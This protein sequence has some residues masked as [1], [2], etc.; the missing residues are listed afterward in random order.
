MPMMK[1]YSPV[2]LGEVRHF[3]A[4]PGSCVDVRFRTKAELRT[5][6]SALTSLLDSRGDDFDHVHLQDHTL[7]VSSLPGATEVTL[8]R[9]GKRPDYAERLCLRQAARF[10]ASLIEQKAN[11]AGSADVENAAAQ[12]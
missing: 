8:H 5:L 1:Q 9:P 11:K 10:E 7:A 6:I 12:P 3:A 4:P 2:V